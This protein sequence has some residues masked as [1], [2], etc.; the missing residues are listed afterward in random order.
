MIPLRSLLLLLALLPL[1]AAQ[2]AD[3]PANAVT[4]EDL[5]SDRQAIFNQLLPPK[6]GRAQGAERYAVVE[7]TIS[8]K[9]F[10]RCSSA[11]PFT[12]TVSADRLM[13][14]AFQ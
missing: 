13:F 9:D 14:Q 7:Q 6:T 4:R 8:V 11:N 2:T 3:T 5:T 10:G 1:Q 12:S